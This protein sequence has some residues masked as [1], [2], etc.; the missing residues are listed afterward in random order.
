[1]R[2]LIDMTKENLSYINLRN[3][4]IEN[5]MEEQKIGLIDES[6][7]TQ[8]I[9][10]G[11]P[12]FGRILVA[13]DGMQM[14]KSALSYAAY[15]SKISGSEIVVINVVKANRDS[16][17]TLPITLRVNLQE[18][19]EKIDIAGSRRVL[20]DEVL[21]TAIEEMTAACKASHMTGKIICKIHGGNPAGEIINLVNLMHFDLII[22]GSR[23]ITSRI[24]GI[25]STTRKI[26][27]TLKIPL[28]IV[29]KQPKYKDE[30]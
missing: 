18:N 30:W 11:L 12:T 21:R 24:Q 22:M 3:K 16:N 25:G 6:S 1:M 20:I 17:N 2:Y 29:Q 10:I 4:V 15:I 8:H 19:E 26:A 14:S 5:G 9:P 7:R 23:R 27:A 13:Y 28:L